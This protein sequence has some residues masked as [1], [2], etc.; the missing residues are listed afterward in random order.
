MRRRRYTRREEEKPPFN[1]EAWEPKTALG[2]DVKVNNVTSIEQIFHEGRRINEPEIIDALLPDLKSE[3]IEIASVQRMTKNNRK[4]KYRVTAVVGDG[5][6]HVGVGAGRDSEVKAAIESA[7]TNAKSNVIPII[8]GCGSWQCLCG[9]AHSVPFTA[10]GTCGSIEVILKPAPRGLGI[11]AS[12]P[13]KK[14]LELAG[15]KDVWTFSKGRTR[16]KY[17]TLMAVYDAFLGMNGMKNIDKKAMESSE[18]ASAAAEATAVATQ[19][20]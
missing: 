1:R 7:F 6:G 12:K 19:S 13:V 17:N 3:V 16:A 14:M 11:V 4:M 15:I 5:R 20:Q 8:M 9:T 2:R 18:V 10:R